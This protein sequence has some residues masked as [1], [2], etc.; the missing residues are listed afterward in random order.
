M[1]LPTRIYI[2]VRG[3]L[4]LALSFAEVLG[5]VTGLL[6][7]DPDLGQVGIGLAG[8]GEGDVRDRGLFGW[9]RWLGAGLARDFGQLAALCEIG[10]RAANY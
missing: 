4:L 8:R 10:G 9:G 5:L 3:E 1:A 7:Y 6:L 2:L